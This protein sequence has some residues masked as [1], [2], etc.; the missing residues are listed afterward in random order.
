[1]SVLPALP[2]AKRVYVSVGIRHCPAIIIP[3]GPHVWSESAMNVALK[4]VIEDG[5]SVRQAAEDFGVPKSTLGDRVSGHAL[6]GAVSGPSRYLDDEEEKELV[7][8]F[9]AVHQ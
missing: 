8:L 1:M 3:I 2:L 9:V 5:Q 6:P 7:R 4:A